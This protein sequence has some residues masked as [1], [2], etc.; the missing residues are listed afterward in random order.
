MPNLQTRFAQFTDQ[1]KSEIVQIA[2]TELSMIAISKGLK[3][4]LTLTFLNISE[5]CSMIQRLKSYNLPTNKKG[6]K[7]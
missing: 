2:Q 5:I 3:Y 1:K 6:L 4:K 7:N